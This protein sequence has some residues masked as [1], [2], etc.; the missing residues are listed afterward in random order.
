MKRGAIIFLSIILFFILILL[1]RITIAAPNDVALQVSVIESVPGLIIEKP[2][3][4]TYFS[5]VSLRLKIT[6]NGNNFWYNLDNG[7]NITFSGDTYFNTSEGAHTIYVFANNSAGITKKNVTF[8][9][10]LSKYRVIYDEYRSSNK[11]TSTNFDEFSFEEIQSLSGIILENTQYGK[12][13]FNSE[14]NVT[15]DGVND[16]ITD[17]DFN[18]NVSFNRIEINSTGLPNF[19]V[20]ATFSLYGLTFSNPRILKDGIV[21]GVECNINSYS[22]GNL[23]FNVTGF[24]VYSV[25]ETPAGQPPAGSNEGGGGGG[26][27]TVNFSID[28]ETISVSLKQGET[29][30]EGFI[31]E[32]FGGSEIRININSSLGELLRIRESEISLKAGE[33]KEV[34]IDVIALETTNPDLYLGKIVIFS[35]TSS[36]EIL[37]SI[38]VESKKPLFDVSARILDEYLKVKPGE[39]LL[40]EIS[41]FNLA[42]IGKVDVL[43]DYEIR[44]SEGNVIT[45]EQETVGV[46]TQTKF[47][48]TFIIPVDE[49]LGEYIFYTA[50]KYD[51]QTGSSSASF[52]VISDKYG[53]SYRWLVILFVIIVILLVILARKIRQAR[54]RGIEKKREELIKGAERWGESYKV[55]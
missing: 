45:K 12:I 19:D 5:N 10:N 11:G 6:S 49:Q 2:T 51:G 26:G 21:C 44:D 33:K 40:V 43:L 27:Q 22:G 1:E 3:S 18:T 31:I 47:V 28:K 50:A 7:A 36:K 25:E 42:G 54:N 39:K 55:N 52:E 17:L 35:G 41:L 13:S 15:N 8:N 32:N 30:R 38:E 53:F 20:N 4:G 46:E 24:S 23:T 9:V 16:G 37:F 29:K 34:F 48:K 14:I